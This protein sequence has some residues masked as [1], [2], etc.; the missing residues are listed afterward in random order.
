MCNGATS[1][2]DRPPPLFCP[3]VTS[4]PFHM[5][6]NVK[7]LCV[8]RGGVRVLDGVSFALA[9]GQALVLRGPNGSGKTTLLRCL[10]GLTPAL[11]GQI[12]MAPDSAAYAGH[13]DGLKAQLSVAENLTFWAEIFGQ[14]DINPA[15]QAFELA[16]LADRRVAELSAGQKRRAALAR[17]LV[18]GRRLWL[19]DEPTVSLDAANTARFG[20]TVTA[21]LQNGGMAVLAT[22]ID[23]GFEAEA[24]D[25]AAFVA[26][27]A[28]RKDDDPFAWDAEP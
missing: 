7:N 11:G 10:A 14:R 12:E 1:A 19:L 5:T 28:A 17:L 23:L 25:I 2:H 16:R 13:A 24:L 3:L 9:P 4:Y 18:T 8:G 22:H 15:L 27:L 6:L 21:H 20:A 26:S